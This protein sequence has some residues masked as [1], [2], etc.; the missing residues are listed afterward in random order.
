MTSQPHAMA[1]P[2]PE[3]VETWLKP[4]ATA[5]GLAAGAWALLARW[6]DRRARRRR[7]DRE[8]LDAL[9]DA[10]RV[11]LDVDRWSLEDYLERARPGQLVVSP[12]QRRDEAAVLLDR[13]EKARRRLW[14]ALG[15]PDPEVERLSPDQKAVL[16]EM[17]R[18]LRLRAR[19]MSPEE[20]A[21]YLEEQRREMRRAAGL[22]DDE[23]P[24]F[25][26]EEPTR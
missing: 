6:L 17:S 10:G 5:V 16:A 8:L 20:R 1:G 7:A 21:A 13:V 25:N 26:D 4:V 11:Q 15:F 3:E 9:A 24:L 2:T 18:T 12:H 22:P 23:G 14:V 19:E